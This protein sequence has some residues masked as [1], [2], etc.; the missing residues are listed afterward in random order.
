M[1]LWLLYHGGSQNGCSKNVAPAW[2]QNSNVRWMA[3]VMLACVVILPLKVLLF[4][5][6]Q[7]SERM[8]M[9]VVLRAFLCSGHA[10]SIIA[11]MM[12]GGL[13]L[14]CHCKGWSELHPPLAAAIVHTSSDNGHCQNKCMEDSKFR[15]HSWQ[16][17]SFGHPLRW[18]RSLH[19]N[20]FLSSKHVKIFILA[21]AQVVQ[22][23]FLKSDLMWP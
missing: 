20:L 2:R 18:R 4:L 10:A 17:Y 23:R 19:H 8:R 6:F 15:T 16:K 22:I 7:S 5:A 13:V 3:A 11:A 14:F 21:G 12:A 1:L 9:M